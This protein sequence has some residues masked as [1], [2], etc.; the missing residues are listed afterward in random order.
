M[1]DMSAKIRESALDILTREG[2]EGLS[3]RKLATLMGC[4]TGV[5]YHHYPDKES[6]L[7]AIAD[8]GYKKILAGIKALPF[9]PDYPV[10]GIT[11]FFV[12]YIREMLSNRPYAYLALMS[13]IPPILEKSTVLRRGISQQSAT[14]GILTTRIREGMERGLIKSGDPELTAQLVWTTCYGLLSRLILEDQT[15]PEQEERLLDGLSGVLNR[16]LKA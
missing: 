9:H 8:E 4:T 14:F 12:G 5:I 1:K 7:S 13:P 3:M 16:M 15:P 11:S 2:Q 6:I 10:E